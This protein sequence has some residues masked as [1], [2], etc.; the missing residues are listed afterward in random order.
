MFVVSVFLLFLYCMKPT[1]E[2]NEEVN[3]IHVI[4]LYYTHAISFL[5]KK[6][7]F[8]LARTLALFP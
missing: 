8:I 5:L 6:E 1:L 3:I 2:I 4:I 7:N